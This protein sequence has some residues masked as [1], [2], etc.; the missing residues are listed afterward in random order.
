MK[1][2]K[3]ALEL[4][5]GDNQISVLAFSPDGS[6]L[7]SGFRRG[8]AIIWDVRRAFCCCCLLGGGGLGGGGASK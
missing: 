2:D 3:P 7:L 5:A 6:K 1:L 8:S 4:D